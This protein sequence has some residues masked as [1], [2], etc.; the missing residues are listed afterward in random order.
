MKTVY[1][2]LFFACCTFLVSCIGQKG[3]ESE[4]EHR[5]STDEDSAHEEHALGGEKHDSDEIIF[6][7]ECAKA[8][9]LKAM[10][11]HLWQKVQAY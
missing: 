7:K 1:N 9:G 10:T 5:H 3:H 11:S 4:K 6:T 2:I 8:A